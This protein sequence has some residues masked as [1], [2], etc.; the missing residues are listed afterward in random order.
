[1]GKEK[2][3]EGHFIGL[4][5]AFGLLFGLPLSLAIGNPGLIGIGLPIGLAIGIAVE[6]KY[7]K[8]GKI[9]PLTK[10]EKKTQK[11]LTIAGIII[12][13]LGIA[14]FILFLLRII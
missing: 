2:Y 14:A 12:F 9:R 13:A 11:T 8:E 5:I 6:E 7:K 10:E 1:M 4:G 3:A